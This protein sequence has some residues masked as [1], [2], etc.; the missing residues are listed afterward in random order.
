MVVIGGVFPGDRGGVAVAIDRVGGRGGNAEFPV[1]APC[2]VA[3]DVSQDELRADFA[4]KDD[5]GTARFLIYDYG[6]GDTVTLNAW[7]SARFE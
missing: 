1:E 6:P 3:D 4:D 2:Q 7:I 5:D